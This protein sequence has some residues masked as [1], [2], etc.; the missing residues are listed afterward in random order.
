MEPFLPLTWYYRK[1]CHI[2]LKIKLKFVRSTSLP[3]TFSCGVSQLLPLRYTTPISTGLVYS[4][5]DF[6]LW[7]NSYIVLPTTRI[8]RVYV[9]RC[10]CHVQAAARVTF[11]PTSAVVW[12]SHP[13]R[14]EVTPGRAYVQEILNVSRRTPRAGNFTTMGSLDRDRRCLNH[15][16]RRLFYLSYSRHGFYPRETFRETGDFSCS[17][18]TTSQL[19]RAPSYLPPH[20]RHTP[21]SRPGWCDAYSFHFHSFIYCFLWRAEFEKSERSIVLIWRTHRPTALFLRIFCKLMQTHCIQFVFWS[22]P[23]LST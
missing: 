5:S 17:L 20:T 23:T 15:A 16:L 4:N 14:R 11:S 22:V 7:N 3:R 1:R 12:S 10:G 6:S 13:G 21:F 9:N 8:V 19:N 2:V 18:F